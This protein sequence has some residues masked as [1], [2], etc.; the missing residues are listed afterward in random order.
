[1]PGELGGSQRGRQLLEGDEG[2]LAHLVM[3]GL[4]SAGY[5][6]QTQDEER[7]VRGFRDAISDRE[8]RAGPTDDVRLLFHLSLHG[9]HDR[10]VSLDIPGRDR[11]LPLRRAVGL[12]DDEEPPFADQ[13]RT[14]ADRDGK[15][16][17]VRQ[18]PS[19]ED[20]ERGGF[21][22]PPAFPT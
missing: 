8:E 10:L 7:V 3:V 1:R 11:P 19:R 15:G 17:D 22:S 20:L 4:G 2:R 13:K 14:Y 12:S 5:V 18:H 16:R 9:L 21:F 6:R